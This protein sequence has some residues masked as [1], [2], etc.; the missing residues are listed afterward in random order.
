MNSMETVIEKYGALEQRVQ[1]LLLRLT[2]DACRH[3]AGHC[4]RHDICEESEH[5]LFLR[6]VREF[7]DQPRHLSNDCGWLDLDGCVLQ[8]GRPPVCYEYFCDELFGSC[9]GPLDRWVLETAGRLIPFA[10]EQAVAGLHLVEIERGEDFE[11]I[12]PER[13][14]RRI[15]RAGEAL[16]ALEHFV[17]S[18]RFKPGQTDLLG[19]IHPLPDEL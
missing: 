5:S 7:F 16:E 15:E 18:G 2:G 3:C 12:R 4:C 17:E 8:Y 11:R 6:R 10:G 19:T 1:A 13:L 9:A 14:L